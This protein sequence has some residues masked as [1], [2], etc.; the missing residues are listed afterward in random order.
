MVRDK[1]GRS[2]SPA[3][4]SK[5]ETDEGGD[6]SSKTGHHRQ[7]E[8]NSVPLQKEKKS[9]CRF[10]HP[11]ACHYCKSE[12]GCKN[13]EK[14][15]FRHVEAEEKPSKKVK[16]IWCETIS[17]LVEG[18]YTIGLCVSRF[19]SETIYST[20]RVKIGIKTAPCTKLKFGKERVH[21]EEVSRSVN[22]MSVVLARQNSKKDHMR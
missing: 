22:L 9:S 6:K 4:N 10:W 14:C 21:R 17:C 12:T 20:E 11:P 1:K 19:L 3:S 8:Q 18:V 15:R 2:S 16:E 5:A 7:K 13:G